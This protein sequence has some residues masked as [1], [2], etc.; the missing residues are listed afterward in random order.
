MSRFFAPSAISKLEN[1]VRSNIMKLCQRLEQFRKD[2]VPVNFS[3]A[4]RSL[5]QDTVTAYCMPHGS[6]LLDSIDFA[7][8]YNS[9]SRGIAYIAV[10]HRHIPI[11]LPIFMAMPRWLV[12]MVSPPGGLQAFDFQSVFFRLKL[13]KDAINLT[14]PRISKTRLMKWLVPKTGQTKRYSRAS[15]TRDCLKARIV[16]TDC[17]KKHGR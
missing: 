1:S 9:Q 2:K 6:D 15:Q 10:F 14:S 16:V 12:K 13:D 17:Y 7:D 3:N 4:F 8:E 11:I 5:A